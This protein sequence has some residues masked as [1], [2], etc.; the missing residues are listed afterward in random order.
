MNRSRYFPAPVL[1]VALFAATGCGSGVVKLKGV[2]NIDGTPVDGATVSFVA[3]DGKTAYTGFTEGGG[4]FNLTGPD[5][6]PGIP[7]GNYKV[8]VVKHAL[9]SS[10]EAPA[11]SPEYMKEMQKSAQEAAKANPKVGFMPGMPRPGT[12][13]THEKSE[14]PA[15]YASA[16]KTPIMVKVPAPSD[17]VVIE[18][19]S[20]P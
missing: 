17:P 9:R 15:D 16:E 7:P 5:G 19:K 6:K 10:G 3:E 14:L 2:V 1:A 12:S 11:G 8:T 20:K 4:N 13:G 18:L